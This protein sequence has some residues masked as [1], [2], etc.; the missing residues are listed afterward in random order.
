MLACQTKLAHDARER[1]LE[2]A[3]GI[4]PVSEAWEASVLPLYEARSRTL[5]YRPRGTTI[6]AEPRVR[7][8]STAVG[9]SV[10]LAK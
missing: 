7:I 5:F 10:R 3:T 8:L 1:S 4:G 6:N 9:M 2:R